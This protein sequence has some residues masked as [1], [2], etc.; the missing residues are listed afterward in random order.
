MIFSTGPTPDP[1]LIED[2]PDNVS[3]EA[4]LGAWNAGYWDA[5]AERDYHVFPGDAADLQPFY[6]D[7]FERGERDELHKVRINER[8]PDETAEGLDC[9]SLVNR[10]HIGRLVR[11]A[12]PARSVSS[13]EGD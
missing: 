4:A 8:L 3:V 13:A 1:K 7:G 6:S 10:R 2:R 12:S 11:W 5:R 9:L